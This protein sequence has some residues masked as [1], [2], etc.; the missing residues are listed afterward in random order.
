MVMDDEQGQLRWELAYPTTFF[1]ALAER[2]FHN[3]QRHL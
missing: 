3:L 1:A 2:A